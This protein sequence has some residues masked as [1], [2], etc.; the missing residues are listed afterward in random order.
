MIIICYYSK[1]VIIIG[2]T[3]CCEDCQEG[4]R[5]DGNVCT[6]NKVIIE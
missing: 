2:S 3:V 6:S 4:T 1:S 5:S